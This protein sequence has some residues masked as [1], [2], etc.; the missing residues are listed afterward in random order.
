L[1]QAVLRAFT[2]K[3]GPL[4]D[5][6][7]ETQP[8]RVVFGT[9]TMRRIRQEA[10]RLGG[11][12]AVVIST[13]GRGERLAQEVLRHLGSIGR[14]TCAQAVMHTP[15]E[16]TERALAIIKDAGTDLLVALG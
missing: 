10:E 14:G 6:I 2:G 5:F 8:A 11:Q 7:Y 13:P 3:E 1:T 15:L 12:R 9:G 16:V 4:Q